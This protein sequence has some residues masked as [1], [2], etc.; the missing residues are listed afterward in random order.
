MKQ[1]RVKKLN[2][3]RHG[4]IYLVWKLALAMSELVV[5]PNT[6]E[7]IEPIAMHK[8]ELMRSCEAELANL[9]YQATIRGLFKN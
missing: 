5:D 1:T 4:Q 3:T 8:S 7:W 6:Y 9:G 2:G